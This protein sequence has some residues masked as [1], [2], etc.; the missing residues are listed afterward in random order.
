MPHVKHDLIFSH[1]SY[2]GVLF[3]CDSLFSKAARE[4]CDFYGE[5]LAEI[6][7]RIYLKTGK[8]LLFFANH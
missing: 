5:L 7:C 2:F 8:A 6:S 1:F 4:V 3:F